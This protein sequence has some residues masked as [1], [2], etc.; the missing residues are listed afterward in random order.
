MHPQGHARAV[1]VQLESLLEHKCRLL[2]GAAV[3]DVDALVKRFTCIAQKSQKEI[4]ILYDFKIRG[5]D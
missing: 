2:A 4:A 5:V 1:A 3:E